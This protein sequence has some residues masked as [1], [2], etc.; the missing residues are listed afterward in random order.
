[1]DHLSA[2]KQFRLS[3]AT[4]AGQR[5]SKRH[6]RPATNCVLSRLRPGQS[7]RKREQ[8]KLWGGQSRLWREQSRRRPGQ[9]RRRRGRSR[10]RREQSGLRRGRSKLRCGTRKLRHG[11]SR[12]FAPQ[13]LPIGDYLKRRRTESSFWTVRRDALVM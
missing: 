10:L 12:Q 3:L 13:N 2:R 1:M 5:R 4:K 7:R 6:T 9:N 8:S 11:V